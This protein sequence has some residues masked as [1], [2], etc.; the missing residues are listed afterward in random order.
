M[1]DGRDPFGDDAVPRALLAERAFNLRWAEVPDGVI[2]LTAADP[3]FPA[4]PAVREALIA[5]ADSG[6]YPYGPAQGL[7][8]FRTAV[9]EYLR[10]RRGASVVPDSVIAT[11]S[12]ASGLAMVARH[13]L[14]AGDEVIVFDPVDFLLAHVAESVG[15]IP[16]R[17]P[18]TRFGE[19][20]L[21][22]LAE[23]VS[24]RTTAIFVCSPHNP[25]GRCFTAAEL[26]DLARFAAER[27]LWVLSDEVWSDICYPPARFHSM[28]GLDA[29]LS[30]RVVVVGGCSKSFALAGLRIGYV[31]CTD[32]NL[33]AELLAGSEHPSTVDGAATIS[34]VAAAA[35]FADARDWLESFVA[36]LQRRR[37]QC[38]AAL[39]A[40]PGVTVDV[41][42]ATF[43]AFPRVGDPSVDTAAIAEQLLAE[44]GVAVV[45]GTPRWFGGGA[46][47]HLRISFAT[48][49]AI[50]D[51]GLRRL[52]RGLDSASDR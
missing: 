8:P 14:C 47:G 35:A 50:L 24:P 44:F 15:A 27:N 1:S 33:A 41:P 39:S 16:V 25:L 28:L 32:P 3:D 11:N 22:R 17:W 7:L 20:D 26:T 23:L 40:I 30:R 5:Y 34:Q 31:A 4:P 13:W 48:S 42:D 45:P 19:L 38:V 36:H 18:V 52:A 21:D 29:E 12:A 2:P 9:A 6:V 43:V 49:E 51:E 46:A 10:D 37:D